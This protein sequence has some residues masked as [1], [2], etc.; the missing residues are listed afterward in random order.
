M[1]AGM[2]LIAILLGS[3]PAWLDRRGRNGSAFRAVALAAVLSF[4]FVQIRA[5][6]LWLGRRTVEVGVGTDRFLIHDQ[7]AGFRLL[8]DS[9]DRLR[10]PGDTLLVVPEGVMLNYLL[11]MRNPT[12]HVNFMP[13]ELIMFGESGIREAFE[14]G[15][16]D[17]VVLIN[18]GAREY[19]YR[20]FGDDYGR[21]LVSWI[22]LNYHVVDRVQESTPGGPAPF[23][24]ILRRNP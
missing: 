16:P 23:A 13:P 3:L 14:R 18:H 7:D 22:E 21:S 1:P 20:M 19:G 17:W 8:L 6:H 15:S 5:A 10:H 2:A 9:L 4:G 11:R 24:A 12:G